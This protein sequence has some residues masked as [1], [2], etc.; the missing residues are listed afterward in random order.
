M[1]GRRY[2]AGGSK[3]IIR[4]RR[5]SR[6]TLWFTKIPKNTAICPHFANPPANVVLLNLCRLARHE[7]K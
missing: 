2:K 4:F 7:K 3:K 5:V 1:R 6:P